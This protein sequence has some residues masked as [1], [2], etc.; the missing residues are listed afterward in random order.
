MKCSYN[1]LNILTALEFKGI[2]LFKILN[3]NMCDVELVK[4]IKGKKNSRR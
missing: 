4:K 2:E 1:V 3:S